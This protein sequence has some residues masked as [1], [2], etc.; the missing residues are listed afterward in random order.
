MTTIL[1]RDRIPYRWFV[2]MVGTWSSYER[3]LRVIRIVWARK[4]GPGTGKGWSSK[5]TFNIVLRLFAWH[6]DSTDCYL[7]ILGLQIHKQRHFGGWIT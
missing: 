3:K 2:K 6:W 7:T 5:L 4:G 1:G